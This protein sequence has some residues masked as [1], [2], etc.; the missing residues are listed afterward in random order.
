MGFGPAV[1]RKSSLARFLE[2][3]I[4]KRGLWNCARQQGLASQPGLVEIQAANCRNREGVLLESRRGPQGT[5][6]PRI[7]GGVLVS[8]RVV[9]VIPAR[10][11]ST[12]LP[13]KL[14][15]SETGQP[16]LQ[17]TWQAAGKSSAIDRLVI[18]AEEPELVQATRAFGA[19]C[20][21]TGAHQWHRPDC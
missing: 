1:L 2:V 6:G 5:G 21:L 12:R 11:A 15:L 20:E 13:R 10:L 7:Q 16:L 14:L 19:Q 8:N 17:H 9:G 4:W 3:E 18:A